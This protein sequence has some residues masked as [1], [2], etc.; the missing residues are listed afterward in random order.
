MGS[1]HNRDQPFPPALFARE[2]SRQQSAGLERHLGKLTMKLDVL[3]RGFISVPEMNS[4][5]SLT[6]S[7]R[8]VLAPSGALP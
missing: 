7:G 5:R 6:I 3:E 8:A 1:P 4:E 2:A